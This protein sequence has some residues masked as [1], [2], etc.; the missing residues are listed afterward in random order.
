MTRRIPLSRRHL[1]IGL[2]LLVLALV[3]WS[4]LSPDTL[5]VDAVA[6]EIGPM[7]V[8]VDEDGRARAVDSYLVTAPVLGEVQR[9]PFREGERVNAGDIVAEIQ[10][11]PLDERSRTQLQA[12]LDA[13]RA[14]ERAAGAAL[15]QARAASEQARRE[16]ERRLALVEAGAL[17]EEQIEQFALAARTR[18]EQAD[19]AAAAAHAAEADARA[20]GAALLGQRAAIAVR[21]PAAGAVARI[22]ERSTRV[23]T[24]GEVILEITDPSALE[25]VID[26]LSADAVRIQPGMHATLSGWGGPEFGAIVR[27][28]EPSAFTRISALGVEEQRVNVILAPDTRPPGLGDD[29]RVEAAIRVWQDD[30]ALTVPS[31]AV[32]QSTTGWQL[33]RVVDGHAR[34]TDVTIGERTGARTQILDGISS[35]ELVVLFPSD[36]LMDGSR[37]QVRQLRRPPT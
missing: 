29:Y 32:F 6:A 33:F 20:A 15:A 35:G 16:Y 24:P 17:A 36:E 7:V 22:P 1:W 12:A 11:P 4:L 28:V 5:A 2:A 23:V 21:A 31:S 26:V 30:Q 18:A 13:A 10:P 37:V 34:L 27:T 19:V 14:R 9:L 25:I 3:A 8:T